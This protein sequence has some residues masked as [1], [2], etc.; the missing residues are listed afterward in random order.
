M[1]LLQE[2]ALA[3]QQLAGADRAPL[4]SARRLSSVPLGGQWGPKWEE[5][6]RIVPHCRL[7][8]V[9]AD[10]SWAERVG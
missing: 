4:R 8:V 3:A 5:R 1:L 6:A 10:L 2:F 7:T 9:A